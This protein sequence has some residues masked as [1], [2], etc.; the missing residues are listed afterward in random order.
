MYISV[1]PVFH[2]KKCLFNI[3]Q[4]LDPKREHLVAYALMSEENSFFDF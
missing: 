1:T 4:N 2:I 3:L